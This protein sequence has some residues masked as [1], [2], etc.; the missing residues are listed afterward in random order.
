MWPR[1]FRVHMGSAMVL[2]MGLGASSALASTINTLALPGGATNQFAGGDSLGG[3]GEWL[4]GAGYP[5]TALTDG[6]AYDSTSNPKA[7]SSSGITTTDVASDVFDTPPGSVNTNTSSV[8]QTTSTVINTIRL[9]GVVAGGNSADALSDAYIL[10][11]NSFSFKYNY[12]NG[13]PT[14]PGG[15]GDGSHWASSGTVLAVNGVAVTSP[16]AG[17]AAPITAAEWAQNGVLPGTAGTGADGVYYVD[18]TVADSTGLSAVPQTNSLEMFFGDDNQPGGDGGF[19]LNQIQ[20]YD[21]TPEP[22]SLALIGVS[23]LMLLRRR[24]RS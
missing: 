10:P 21:A 14:N 15:V 6:I 9:Y 22:A 19:G 13:N 18:I 20:A 7:N 4:N 2:A 16:V 12:T 17:N 11:P 8:A 5:A 1:Q 24:A 23:G 3:S